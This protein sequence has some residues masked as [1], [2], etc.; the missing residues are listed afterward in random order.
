MATKKRG[1][2]E[3][4][5]ARPTVFRSGRGGQAPFEREGGP[6]FGSPE[7]PQNAPGARTLQ[8][9]PPRA[10]ATGGPWLIPGAYRLASRA[11]SASPA[12]SGGRDTSTFSACASVFHVGGDVRG[13]GEGRRDEDVTL[14]RLV[15]EAIDERLPSAAA[16]QGLAGA[17]SGAGFPAQRRTSPAQLPMAGRAGRQQDSLTLRRKVVA[18]SWPTFSVPRGPLSRRGQSSD[19][20]FA[21]G[22]QSIRGPMMRGPLRGLLASAPVSGVIHCRPPGSPAGRRGPSPSAVPWSQ[23]HVRETS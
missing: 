1:G 6:N 20:G 16:P 18:W 17:A 7:W 5:T 19:P 4:T 12:V 22:F 9:S 14:S 15:R 13:G 8:G 21:K 23:R 2:N 3:A 10:A 11:A